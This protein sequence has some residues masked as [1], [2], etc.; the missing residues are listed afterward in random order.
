M[1][2]LGAPTPTRCVLEAVMWIH[3]EVRLEQLLRVAFE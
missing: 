3:R 1:D 2:V